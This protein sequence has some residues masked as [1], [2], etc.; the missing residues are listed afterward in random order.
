MYILSVRLG[1]TLI[2]RM[3]NCRIICTISLYRLF[4]YFLPKD[5]LCCLTICDGVLSFQTYGN[6]WGFLNAEMGACFL[7]YHNWFLKGLFVVCFRSPNYYSCAE[8]GTMLVERGEC[9]ICF[10]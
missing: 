6:I 10:P 8:I 5:L 7:F 1:F 4:F 9:S 3:F 2:Q